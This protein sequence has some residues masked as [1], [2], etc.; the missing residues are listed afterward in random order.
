MMMDQVSLNEKSGTVEKNAYPLKFS[1]MSDRKVIVK[2]GGEM[3][4]WM[5]NRMVRIKSSGIC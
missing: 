5:V 3:R 2:G 1:F 4:E